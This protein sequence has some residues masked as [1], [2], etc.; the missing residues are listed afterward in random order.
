MNQ[1]LRPYELHYLRSPF[2]CDGEE[3]LEYVAM[4]LCLRNVLQQEDRWVYI[5]PREPR[6]LLRTFLRR[7]PHFANG[8][9]SLPEQFFLDLFEHHDELSISQ[10]I[11][12]V[13]DRIDENP[14]V[15]KTDYVYKDMSD[16]G[17]CLLF[18]M[19]T[20]EGERKLN[21]IIPDYAIDF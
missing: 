5:T 16:R 2:F 11:G 19:S 21:T 4:D 17:L 12:L 3:L 15:F 6:P 1:I 20:T 8:P 13:A 7:G 14:A 10:I 9:F 18:Y